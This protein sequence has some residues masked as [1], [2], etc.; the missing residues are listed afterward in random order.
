ME[1]KRNK[2]SSV[3]QVSLGT[4]D[5]AVWE[6]RFSG[7]LGPLHLPTPRP[8]YQEQ[9]CIRIGLL[10]HVIGYPPLCKDRENSPGNKQH[11]FGGKARD[12]RK[13]Q[14]EKKYIL[15]RAERREELLQNQYLT[16]S[17]FQSL[18]PLPVDP[19]HTQLSKEGLGNEIPRVKLNLELK[20]FFLILTTATG[21]RERKRT[22]RNREE[23]EQSNTKERERKGGQNRNK[24]GQIKGQIN[25]V[26][27]RE[28]RDR[29]IERGQKEMED[30]EPYTL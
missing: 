6:I 10:P 22:Y 19:G 11:C 16:L 12:R 15:S 25:K 27:W 8:E 1:K 13:L 9:L 28:G 5:H 24:D 29:A 2:I 4:S 26:Q 17:L 30:R 7:W 3:G 21:G 18:I 20:H 23:R 14:R